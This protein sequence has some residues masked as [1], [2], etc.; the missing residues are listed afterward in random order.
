M[1]TC[2]LRLGAGQVPKDLLVQKGRW[3]RLELDMRSVQ[4]FLVFFSKRSRVQRVSFVYSFSFKYKYKTRGDVGMKTSLRK[5]SVSVPPN[6]QKL[7][8]ENFMYSK[9]VS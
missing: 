4:F 8:C 5:D 6:V 9:K 7:H 2:T 3:R 1:M